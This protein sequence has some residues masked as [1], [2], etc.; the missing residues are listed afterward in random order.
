MNTRYISKF[1]YTPMT[2]SQIKFKTLVR[3]LM[4]GLAR[5]WV[6][7]EEIEKVSCECD[8]NSATESPSDDL[9]FLVT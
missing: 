6:E 7:V 1:R 3:R 4:K 9:S 8:L 2:T 5:N